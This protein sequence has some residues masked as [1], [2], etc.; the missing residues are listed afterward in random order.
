M[1]AL[2]LVKDGDRPVALAAERDGK[3]YGYVSNV[4]AF[5]YNKPMSVDFLIDQKMTYQTQ[6]AKQATAIIQAGVIGK[7]D[8]PTNRFLLD[9][10]KAEANRITLAEVFGA[11]IPNTTPVLVEIQLG[12]T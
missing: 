8:R 4:K 7:I 5:V 12:P 9:H 1:D 2:Y 10:M 11:S 6:T 3:L